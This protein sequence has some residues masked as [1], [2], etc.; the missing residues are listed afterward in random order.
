MPGSE[1][2]IR[3][4]TERASRHESLF[5]PLD[6]IVIAPDR[7]EEDSVP[8]AESAYRELLELRDAG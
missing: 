2:K 3:E 8:T 1:A 4:L 6:S 7:I 5:H